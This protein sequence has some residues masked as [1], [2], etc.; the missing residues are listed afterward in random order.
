MKLIRI[1]ETLHLP[2]R[3]TVV[4]SLI[5]MF[6][7][8]GP[9]F[10]AISPIVLETGKISLSVDG[11]GTSN[12]TGAIQV[13]KPAGAT[14]RS[15]YLA[16]ASTGASGRVLINGDVKLNGANVVFQSSV[17]S[18]ISSSNH[19]ANVTTLVKSFIDAA[20][21]GLINITVAEVNTSGI[22][23][24]ILAVIFDDPN[25]T[26]TNT[27]SLLFGAQLVAGDTFSITLAQPIN[28]ADP[29]LS[30]DMS[31]GISFGFQASG[32]QQFSIVNVNAQRL[33][34]SAGGEDD[35]VA[36]DGA[37]QTVGGIGDT[38]ANPTNP[39]ATPTDPRSDDELYSLLQFVNTGDTAISVF[40]QNPSTD[41]NIFFA[42][43][44]LGSTNAVVGEGILLSPHTAT[45]PLG[46]SHTVTAKV[47]NTNG[48]P[49][50]NR[51]VK[52]EIVSGPNNG[53]TANTLTNATGEATF[54]YTGNIVG[55][56]QIVAS[57]VTSSGATISSNTVT[58]QWVLGG[59]TQPPL[60]GCTA[61][62]I[63]S[64]TVLTFS[65]SDN[66]DPNPSVFI[67]DTASS[68]VAG[69]FKTGDKVLV[70]V[71]PSLVPS[72]VALVGSVKARVQVNGSP[73]IF[74]KDA[75]NNHRRRCPA[76]FNS[77]I[78]LGFPYPYFTRCA[79]ESP[80]R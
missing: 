12:A 45:N 36:A 9:A 68:F 27:I 37:L 43:F 63:A 64:G 6:V 46:T 31:L 78:G 42:A 50:V 67:M 65:I 52:F 22:D 75:S 7:M 41:D 76:L 72:Q 8:V 2:S 1:F 71:L 44:F 77:G 80:K 47:V 58:K 19:F 21:A 34:T 59:D 25:Q 30:L 26:T 5:A 48:Q 56:D 74:G 35:G 69:P 20:P 55:T 73:L 38:N 79:W 23:G 61:L 49:I 29:N 57:F 54:T 16:A 18:N 3:D 33:T 4:A 14:V 17:A 24:E 11:L 10:S 66:A 51:N 32:A 62:K 70:R 39:L 15:A 13:N 28:E 60:V 40:T 53:V